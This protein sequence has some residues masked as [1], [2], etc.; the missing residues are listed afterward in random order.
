[1]R[2]G[3]ERELQLILVESEKRGAELKMLRAQNAP[4]FSSMFVRLLEATIMRTLQIGD[5]LSQERKVADLLAP[6]TL[7]QLRP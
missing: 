4:A 6:G 2:D 1:M 7:G 5:Q 3:M